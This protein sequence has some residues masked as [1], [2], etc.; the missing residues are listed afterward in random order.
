ME[1]STF[2]SRLTE[3]TKAA[4]AFLMGGLIATSVAASPISVPLGGDYSILQ[5][6]NGRYLDA[7]DHA[8][9]NNATT[10]GA[11]GDMSQVWTITYQGGDDYTIQQKSTGLFL[12]AY[13]QNHKDYSA[14]TRAPRN[15]GVQHWRIIMSE[16][17][18]Y[19]IQ[20]KITGR[21][22]DAYENDNDNSVVTRE[23]ENNSTQSWFLFRLELPTQTAAPV[24]LGEY[25][26]RQE[27]NMQYM[28]AW[29]NTHNNSA[30]TRNFHDNDAQIWDIK[31]L[32]GDVYT[33]QQKFSG[34]YLDAYVGN[35]DHDV[36]TRDASGATAQKWV[37]ERLR[38]DI[39]TL[40]Q[41]R[42]GRY[43]DAYL[44][45][46]QDYSIVTRPAQ[47]NRTQRW[48]ITLAN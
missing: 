6:S 35:N 13:H 9:D 25:H 3:S 43:L 10:R 37:I 44:N 15:P 27:Q 12:D 38:G 46:S 24:L 19:T 1:I 34:M 36:V 47:D 11:Q 23:F 41:V 42:S 21:F 39:Y 48:Y 2:I 40:M 17:G 16:E 8:H 30:A 5:A 45:E 20:Q 29:V 22:L 26:V 4:S 7:Y 33:L 14:N 18:S 32:V 31:H 28:D